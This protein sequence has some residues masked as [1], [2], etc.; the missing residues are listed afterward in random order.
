MERLKQAKPIKFGHRCC[1]CNLFIFD[2][3]SNLNFPV[4][5][6]PSCRAGVQIVPRLYAAK[7]ANRGNACGTLNDNSETIQT[8]DNLCDGFRSRPGEP[9]LPYHSDL[10]DMAQFRPNCL[11]SNSIY[12]YVK[13]TKSWIR[14]GI[15]ALNTRVP[16]NT[17]KASRAIS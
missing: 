1:T 13:R 8:G 16:G 14:V 7:H 12:R 10:G 17:A 4:H 6:E 2:T 11:N 5:S 3:C 9:P 15:R